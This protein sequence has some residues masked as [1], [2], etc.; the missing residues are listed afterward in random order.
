MTVSGGHRPSD[1]GKRGRKKRAEAEEARQAEE[2]ERAQKALTADHVLESMDFLRN[3]AFR[4][5]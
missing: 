5:R 2:A 4:P 3:T 1:R